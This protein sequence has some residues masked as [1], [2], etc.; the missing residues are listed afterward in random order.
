MLDGPEITQFFVIDRRELELHLPTLFG[1]QGEIDLPATTLGVF[2]HTN[3][4]R[5]WQK[6]K[7]SKI[8][9]FDF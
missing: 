1:R 6:K 5:A 2:F 8:S 4:I 7:I 3:S 9:H